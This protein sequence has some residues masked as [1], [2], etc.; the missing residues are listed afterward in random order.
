FWRGWA[1]NPKFYYFML[2]SLAKIKKDSRVLAC[3]EGER[4]HTTSQHSDSKTS[5]LQQ[6]QKQQQA[7]LYLCL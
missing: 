3:H 6:V 7:Y 5:I 4:S 1:R 2:F